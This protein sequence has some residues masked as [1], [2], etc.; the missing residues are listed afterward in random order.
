MINDAQIIKDLD[1]LYAKIHSDGQKA[2]RNG[3][4]L[5]DP[6]LQQKDQDQRRG[7]ALLANPKGPIPKNLGMLLNEMKAIEPVQYYYPE[8]D[9]H[10]TVMDLISANLQ[11]TADETL[12]QKAN[13]IIET[14]I[15]GMAPFDIH[16]KG[17]IVSNGAILAKGYYNGGLPQLRDKIR[18]IAAEYDF[19]LE[20]RYQSISAHVTIARFI[21]KAVS[22]ELLL[23]KIG[24]YHDFEIGVT[25]VN[26][27]E[28]VIH[29]WYNSRKNVIRK[30]ILEG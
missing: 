1:A 24:D 12:I 18:K 30:F 28:L 16:F 6:Y 19:N 5:I 14:A 21:S 20:E 26:D 7:L 3:M 15:T 8:T 2:I 4:E 27:L 23:A 10:V 29:D 11:F 13:Q 17:I 9:F 22:S 25:R